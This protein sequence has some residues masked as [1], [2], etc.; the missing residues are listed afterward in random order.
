VTDPR[1]HD[2]NVH[3]VVTEYLAQHSRV[4]PSHDNKAVATDAPA[5]LLSQV[6]GTSYRFR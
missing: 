1:R 3:Q 4:A 6:E 2:V 5:D